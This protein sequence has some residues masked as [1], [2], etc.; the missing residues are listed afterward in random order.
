MSRA[1]QGQIEKDLASTYFRSGRERLET[2]KIKDKSGSLLANVKRKSIEPG[3]VVYQMESAS[4]AS[5]LENVCV[6]T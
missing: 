3:P 2:F 1:Q 5:T 4:E 6:R